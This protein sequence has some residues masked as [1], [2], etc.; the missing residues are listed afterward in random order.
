M[1]RRIFGSYLFRS[2]FAYALSGSFVSALPVL[3]MPIL[4]RHLTTDEYGVLGL[5]NMSLNIVAAFTGLSVHGAISR[6]YFESDKINFPSYVYNCLIILV[7]ATLTCLF[8]A[9]AFYKIIELFLPL[10]IFWLNVIVLTAAAQFLILVRLVIWQV[11]RKPILY[12]WTRIMQSALIASA[13]LFFLFELDL[14]WRS[15]ALASVLG[16]SVVALISIFSLFKNGYIKT[17]F[18]KSYIKHA[19][20]FSLPLIAIEIGG[21]ILSSIDSFLVANILGVEQAGLYIVGAQ[22]GMALLLIASAINKAFV[23]WLY[24][25]LKTG[26]PK[27]KL[28]IMK[29]TYIFWSLLLVSAAV[30]SQLLPIIAGFVLGKDFSNVKQL[31]P[32][33]AFGGAFQGMYY[34]VC[35]YFY[36]VEKTNRLAWIF[37]ASTIFNIAIVYA[38]TNSHGIVGASAGTMLSYLFCFLLTL[39]C[40]LKIVKLP[41]SLRAS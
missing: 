20:R 11:E 26:T 28:D 15:N 5:F 18:N 27:A 33:I 12:L 35:N 19:I 38:L 34:L 39:S 9:N 40:S 10:D 22:I 25:K 37:F 14:G 30:L 29:M 3:L 17:L 31:I 32:F 16:A 4:T 21:L 13:T 23:P 2:S 41:W 6:Q 24:E 7:A 36:Y 1:L 8:I